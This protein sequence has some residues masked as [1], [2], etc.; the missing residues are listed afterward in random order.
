MTPEQ[1]SRLAKQ[2]ARERQLR[3][4]HITRQTL[5]MMIAELE[6]RVEWLE[7]SM[8]PGDASM[9]ATCSQAPGDPR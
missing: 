4:S 8:S 1:L 9:P 6:A 2:Y 3:E 5:C 7:S